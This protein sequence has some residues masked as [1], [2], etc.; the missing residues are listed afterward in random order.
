[1]FSAQSGESERSGVT[2][3][4]QRRDEDE[5]EALRSSEAPEAPQPVGRAEAEA[6]RSACRHYAR[7]AAHLRR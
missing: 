4:G 7:R 6:F 3:L 2:A 1:M 5:R